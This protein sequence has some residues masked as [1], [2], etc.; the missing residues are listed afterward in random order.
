M[1][2]ITLSGY[3][4]GER[5]RLDDD[6]PL[7]KGMHLLVTVLPLDLEAEWKATAREDVSARTET[8]SEAPPSNEPYSARRHKASHRRTSGR[9]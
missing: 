6:Y 3:F 9:K 2:F 4:D 1:K 7:G 5:I 8:A